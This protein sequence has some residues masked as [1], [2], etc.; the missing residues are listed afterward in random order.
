MAMYADFTYMYTCIFVVLDLQI[1]SSMC[2]F[3]EEEREVWVPILLLTLMTLPPFISLSEKP[4]MEQ[5]FWMSTRYSIS[6]IIG[7]GDKT[8]IMI[9]V[10]T[11]NEV[12]LSAIL[13]I[14]SPM[15]LYTR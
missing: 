11:F 4:L 10:I 5:F 3:L 8:I 12:I 1:L 15:H 7:M 14:V 13:I 9:I 6:S 2:P